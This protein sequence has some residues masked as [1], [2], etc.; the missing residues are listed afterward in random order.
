[1][2]VCVTASGAFTLLIGHQEGHL[3]C[4]KLSDEVF[5]WLSVWSE[6][7]IICIWSS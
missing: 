4:R 3:A 5:V 7:Q 2:G 1:M 6:V